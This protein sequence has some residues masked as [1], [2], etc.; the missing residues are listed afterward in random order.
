M[1]R[2][3]GTCTNRDQGVEI[4][5]R[6]SRVFLVFFHYM[7]NNMASY[8]GGTKNGVSS[9]SDIND[10]RSKYGDPSYILKSK[11]SEFDEF[12]GKVEYTVDYAEDG[13][14]FQIIED[15]LAMIVVLT[16]DE[17]FDYKSLRKYWRIDSSS[18]DHLPIAVSRRQLPNNRG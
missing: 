15:K 17:N 10:I 3:R 8:A 11:Q 13:I 6:D 12:P 4:S 14:E 18:S 2:A 5:Y 9:G 16:P 1:S 7:S